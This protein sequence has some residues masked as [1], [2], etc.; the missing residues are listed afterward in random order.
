MPCD[1]I[2]GSRVSQK[3]ATLETLLMMTPLQS[4]HRQD[5]MYL[6]QK[7]QV[8]EDRVLI[9]ACHHDQRG[10]QLPGDGEGV[11][12]DGGAIGDV[13]SAFDK[14]Q[15]FSFP[16]LPRSSRSFSPVVSSSSM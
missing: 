7:D 15:L 5:W 2:L 3:S 1:L 9:A 14:E 4:A 8:I 12:M 13:F 6:F 10:V 11:E 16:A